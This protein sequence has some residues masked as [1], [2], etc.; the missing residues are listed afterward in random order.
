[1]L[2]EQEKSYSIQLAKD[3]ILHYLKT[4][5]LLNI[6]VSTIEVLFGKDTPLLQ[7]FG[8][9]VTLKLGHNLRGCIGTIVTDDTLFSNIINNAVAAGL[10]DPRFPPITLDEYDNL[11][12]EISVMGEVLPVENFDEIEIGKH[13]LIVKQGPYQGLL[14][15]QVATEYNW[16]IDTFLQQTCMKA[17]L[18][19]QAVYEDETEFYFFSCEVFS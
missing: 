3:S 2:T 18:S 12:F 6:S 8:C 7:E 4:S 19:P 16:D 1:M 14:L 15:P 13:G 5:T 9:F 11:S 10:R 17:G